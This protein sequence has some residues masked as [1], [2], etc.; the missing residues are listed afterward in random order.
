MNFCISPKEN[1]FFY[2]SFHVVL[3]LDLDLKNNGLWDYEKLYVVCLILNKINYDNLN[4]FFFQFCPNKFGVNFFSWIYIFHQIFSS[5]R[6]TVL[7]R[8]KMKENNKYLK[9][10][11]RAESLQFKEFKHSAILRSL[12]L[13]NFSSGPPDF[14]RPWKMGKKKDLTLTLAWTTSI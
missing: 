13:R 2:V 1:K 5:T 12:T 11:S 14:S 3:D 8:K 9:W 4:I 10:V 6:I 7:N